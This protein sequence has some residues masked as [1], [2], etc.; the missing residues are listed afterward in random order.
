LQA[1]LGMAVLMITHDLGVVAND[2]DEV[3]VMYHGRVVESGPLEAI[4]RDASHPYLK[5]LLRA[6]PRFHMTAD[7]RLVPIREIR[8]EGGQLLAARETPAPAA[9]ETP[10]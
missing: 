5:A 9:T 7:E 6:V 8:P 4:F 10:L 1:Q 2:A 3:V